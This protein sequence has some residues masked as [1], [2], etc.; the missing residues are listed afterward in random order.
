MSYAIGRTMAAGVAG[1]FAFIL[2]TFLTFAQLS[3]SRRGHTG[4]LFDPATQHPKV[5]AVWKEIEPLPRVIE[6]PPI[7]LAGMLLFG[8][9]YAFVYRSVAPGWPPGVSR[10]V[11]RLALV[12]WLS[13][14]FAEFMGP[15]NVLHQPLRLSAIAWSFWAVAAVAEAVG[16]VYVLEG[17]PVVAPR[18][19]RAPAAKRT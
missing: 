16:I 2:G 4:L 5:I 1:G 13:T 3:G 7:I 18:E 19:P 10:R 14:V 15:F 11:W 6:N 17:R 8:L 9:A 12:I